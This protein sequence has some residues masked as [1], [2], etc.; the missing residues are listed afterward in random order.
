M[1]S[2]PDADTAEQQPAEGETRA[3]KSYVPEGYEDVEAFLN[4]AK[5]IHKLDRE[6]DQHNIDAAVDDLKFVSCDIDGMGQWDSA[7]LAD[8]NG[9]GQPSITNNTLPQFVGQVIGDRRMNQ[10]SI[11]VLPRE[12]GDV[13]I[14]SI[15]SDLVRNIEVQS[16]AER[17]YSQAF[18]HEVTCGIGNFRVELDW[19]D[20]DVFDRD[21]FI[22]GIPNPLSVTWDCMAVDPTGRDADHCSVDD[23]MPRKQ[24]EK[25]YPDTPAGDFDQD[26]RDEG[27]LSDQTVRVTEY[28]RMVERDR[29]IALMNDGK[30]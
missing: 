22:R 30:V 11:K 19:T 3:K 10:T 5:E 7:V 12:D 2:K 28:W 27:W 24:Y 1:A 18:E 16:R 4:E 23:I 8:R 13:D 25:L 6:A 9:L 15:R 17:V 26:H 14:A 21:I 29:V 20:D